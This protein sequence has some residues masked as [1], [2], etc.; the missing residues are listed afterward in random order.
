MK[1]LVAVGVLLVGVSAH[2][3]YTSS[4][5]VGA[6]EDS[7]EQSMHAGEVCK[8]NSDG[9]V[10]C[11]YI[12]SSVYEEPPAPRLAHGV[13]TWGSL[14]PQMPANMPADQKYCLKKKEHV[15]A[16][17]ALGAYSGNANALAETYYW[18]GFDDETS[19]PVVERLQSV[20]VAGHWERSYV[21]QWDGPDKA[22]GRVPIYVRWMT[23]D[24]TLPILHF[25]LRKD[26]EFGCWFLQG[27][28]TPS[29]SVQ[30]NGVYS[31]G[32]VLSRDNDPDSGQWEEVP[33]TEVSDEP[34]DGGF[35]L[36]R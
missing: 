21:E 14:D 31:Q 13:R 15:L 24:A 17:F 16:K 1:R 5:P 20:A 30:L 23:D 28:P 29:E 22:L 26:A 8:R 6:Q 19:L 3:Q 7:V 12:G 25:T 27:V 11:Q 4:T 2:A 35:V 34:N 18:N 10:V 36:V 33:R 32:R 9:Q